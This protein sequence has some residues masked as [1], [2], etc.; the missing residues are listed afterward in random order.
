MKIP[1][2]KWLDSEMWERPREPTDAETMIHRAGAK[3]NFVFDVE[4][5]HGCQQFTSYLDRYWPIESSK[6]TGKNLRSKAEN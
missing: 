3:A 5:Y 2:W 4:S 6:F 1:M